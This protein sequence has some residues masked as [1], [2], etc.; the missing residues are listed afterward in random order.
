MTTTSP[1]RSDMLVPCPTFTAELAGIAANVTT[2]RTFTD[3]EVMAVVKADAFG[4][5]Q[6]YVACAALHAGAT[7]L[8]VTDIADGRRLRHAGIDAPILAWLHP[9]GIDVS[10]AVQGKVDVAVGSI[11][12]LADLVHRAIAPVRV[13]LNV[14]AG[15]ARGGVPRHDWPALK[16]IARRGVRLGRI[17][18]V[19]L[20]GHLPDAD[21]ADPKL[22]EGGV[23]RLSEAERMMGDEFGPLIRHLASTAATLTDPASH[24]D[25]VRI[26]AGLVGIDP[27][28]TVPLRGAAWLSAP[29]VH[30]CTA[31]PGTRVG[32]GGSY[33]TRCD[34]HLAVI[35][36]GYADGIP[37]ALS[38]AA[39][40]LI[41]DQRHPIVGKVS[42]DQIVVDTGQ[43]AYPRGT[44]ATIFGPEG[45]GAPTIAEW[46]EWA[47]TIP[48]V[49]VSG[50][51]PRVR[52]V[53]R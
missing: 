28:G 53:H 47:G 27:S 52:K 34:T 49:I 7:W 43:M 38:T 4:H 19:G 33:V 21:R 23:R 3:A 40:V 42:M 22:N 37:R 1:P 51:G 5:G 2:V 8:G 15:I 25:L 46:A 44:V 30:S 35:G 26:G 24:F 29:I 45:T 14:D 39:S 12:E 48:H 18:V 50:I 36:L 41:G 31:R 13:H 16:R 10:A 9:S 11:E 32:Y 20:M 6:L 17:E